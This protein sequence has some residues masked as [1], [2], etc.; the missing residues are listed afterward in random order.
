MPSHP[1]LTTKA[2]L[3]ATAAF[4]VLIIFGIADAG[5]RHVNVVV[6]NIVLV[7]QNDSLK[8]QVK[9]LELKTD[10]DITMQALDS[11]TNVVQDQILVVDS[12]S[13][14]LDSTK[15]QL[16]DA[17]LNSITNTYNTSPYRL[18]PVELPDSES[19]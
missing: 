1:N 18:E 11:L 8:Q 12:I 6:N 5:F 7:E 9:Q 19:D 10:S 2:L 15:Q 17:E 4:V 3:V 16:H 14:R 13:L